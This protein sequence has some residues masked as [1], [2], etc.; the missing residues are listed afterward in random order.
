M[1]S[2]IENMYTWNHDACLAS[3]GRQNCHKAVF[4][5]PSRSP[6]IDW[7]NH[8]ET[9]K[10]VI[11][12]PNRKLGETWP[13]LFVDFARWCFFFGKMLHSH[14]PPPRSADWNHQVRIWGACAD[15]LRARLADRDNFLGGGKWGVAVRVAVC[16]FAK[17]WIHAHINLDKNQDQRHYIINRTPN[18]SK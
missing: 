17:V 14:A 8:K 2:F 1:T 4:Y 10:I 16:T 15:W 7:R 12:R 9:E 11:N 5:C 13:A 3:I 6:K 18:C